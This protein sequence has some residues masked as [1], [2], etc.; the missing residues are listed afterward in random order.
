MSHRHPGP[1]AAV[2]HAPRT[3]VKYFFPMNDNYF[4]LCLWDARS[5]APGARRASSKGVD[6]PALHSETTGAGVQVRRVF[7]GRHYWQT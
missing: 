7:D 4:L 3:C 1:K 6:G 5:A 2:R